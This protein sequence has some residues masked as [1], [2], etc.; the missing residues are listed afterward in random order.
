MA[1][2]TY[3]LKS[4]EPFFIFLFLGYVTIEVLKFQSEMEKKKK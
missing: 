1:S 4:L 2:F 3:I